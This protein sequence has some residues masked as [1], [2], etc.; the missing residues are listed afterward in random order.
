MILKCHFDLVGH[1][2]IVLL[3]LKVKVTKYVKYVTLKFTVTVHV[4]LIYFLP[5]ANGSLQ[6]TMNPKGMIIL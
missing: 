1:I 2:V 4:K 3:S 5:K 6:V